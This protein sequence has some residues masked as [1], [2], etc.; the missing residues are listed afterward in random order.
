MPGLNDTATAEMEARLARSRARYWR[1][2]LLVMGCLLFVWAAAGF[3][4]AIFFADRL[5]E[6]TLPGT[7]FPLGFWFAQQGSIVVFVVVIL[8][9]CVV[10]NRLDRQHH[11]ERNELEKAA[12]KEAGP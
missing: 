10:M 9:Y 1:A 12:R 7:H 6:F 5:N 11:A 3:G 4:A 8:L 2:N